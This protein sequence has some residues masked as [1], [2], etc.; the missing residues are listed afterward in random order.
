[1]WPRVSGLCVR[2]NGALLPASGL[3]SRR[4]GRREWKVGRTRRVSGESL[5][6]ILQTLFNYFVAV[7][8]AV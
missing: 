2:T 5:L 3:F 1:M 4:R 8:M 6:P 7:A